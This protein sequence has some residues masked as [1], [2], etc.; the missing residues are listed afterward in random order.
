MLACVYA[1]FCLLVIHFI[2]V[3]HL[4]ICF[5]MKEMKKGVDL[6][7]LGGSGVR[8][9][10]IIKISCMEKVYSIKRSRQL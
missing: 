8:G 1:F 4:S 6:E 7:W 9:E 3:F 2:L 5:L 10:T